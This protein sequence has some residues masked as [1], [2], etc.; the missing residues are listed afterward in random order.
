MA[1]VKRPYYYDSRRN[2]DRK[3]PPKQGV[4]M[5][6]LAQLSGVAAVTI[7]TYIHRGLLGRVKFYGSATRYP[8][9]H[10]VRLLAIRFCRAQGMRQL[11]EIRR[12][13]DAW[14]PADMEHWILEHPLAPTTLAALGYPV[15]AAQGSD[16]ATSPA[17]NLD[18]SPMNTVA[19]TSGILPTESWRRVML[20]PGLELQVR[21]DAGAVVQSVAERLV[22]NFTELL[23]A[24]T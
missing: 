6:E 9:G 10:L 15:A 19:A 4:T 18:V 2:R 7:K 17:A 14:A 11:D 24:R 3:P 21:T 12:K 1:R 13:L 22:A 23:T 20:M 8:R 5:V 16:S